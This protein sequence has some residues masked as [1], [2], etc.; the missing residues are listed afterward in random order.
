MGMFVTCTKRI[1]TYNEDTQ[2]LLKKLLL[3]IFLRSSTRSWVGLLFLLLSRG[4][5]AF[6]KVGLVGTEDLALLW[7]W[8]RGVGSAMTEAGVGISK[9]IGGE[10]PGVV[11]SGIAVC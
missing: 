2:R 6:W 1:V 8:G 9:L 10:L 7:V 5:V 3:Q 4:W 11:W